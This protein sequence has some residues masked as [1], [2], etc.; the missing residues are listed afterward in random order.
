[1]ENVM[2]KEVRDVLQSIELFQGL[3]REDLDKLLK[4]CQE[5]SFNPDEIIF[6]E[7][8]MAEKFYLILQGHVEV[9]KNYGLPSQDILAIRGAGDTFGE[10]A[11]IDELPRSATLKSVE[12]T[13]CLVQSK[14]D[15]QK[16]LKEN[17]SITL[18]L[19]K[20]VSAMVRQSNESFISRASVRRTSNWKKPTMISRVAQQELINSERLSTLGKFASMVLHDLQKS[21]LHPQRLRRDDRTDTRGRRKDQQIWRKNRRRS[22]VDLSRMAGELLDFSRG[23]IRL[24][25]LPVQLGHL[26]S[27]L[28]REHCS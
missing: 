3:S 10:M 25:L 24:N 22:R 26:L 20:S 14:E 15:F 12:P 1:M 4:I 5:E 17:S 2:I 27:H 19:M 6:R 13:L 7:G 28:A 23:D 16:L 9:W 8:D 11:L 18:T 21:H